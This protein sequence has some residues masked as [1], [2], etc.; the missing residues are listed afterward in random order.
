MAK[1]TKLLFG[2]DYGI[3]IF[4]EHNKGTTIRMAVPYRLKGSSIMV[5]QLNWVDEAWSNIKQKVRTSEK[6]GQISHM[7]VWMGSMSL[8]DQIGG[9]QH[10]GQGFFG[11]CIKES[12]DEN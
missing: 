4:S 5:E 2:N 12:K 8:K 3:E 10:F 7:L 9:Q 6:L 1:R 11:K